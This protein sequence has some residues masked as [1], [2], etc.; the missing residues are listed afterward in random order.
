[1][2]IR[3]V[4][5]KHIRKLPSNFPLTAWKWQKEFE[6]TRDTEKKITFNRIAKTNSK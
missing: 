4:K 1:M 3:N 6:M 2:I 5:L